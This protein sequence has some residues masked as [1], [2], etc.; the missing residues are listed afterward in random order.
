MASL[1]SVPKHQHETEMKVETSHSLSGYTKARQLGSLVFNSRFVHE[2][3]AWF[4]AK[5]YTLH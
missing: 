3:K 5:V 4:N 1:D 2:Q